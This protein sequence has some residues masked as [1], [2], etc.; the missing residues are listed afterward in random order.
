MGGFIQL[1]G[2]ANYQDLSDYLNDSR[3]MEGVNYVAEMYPFTSAGFWWF[4]NKISDYINNKNATVEQV[5]ARVNGKHPANGL[6]DRLFYF[7]RC[8]KIFN[9][10]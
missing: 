9:I 5:S 8:K 10:T 2:R 4:N 1:T 6:Q 7:S 3:I